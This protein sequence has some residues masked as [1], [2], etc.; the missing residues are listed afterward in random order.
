MGLKE[1]LSKIFKRQ[2][3]EENVEERI[4]RL[5]ID[6]VSDRKLSKR[7]E[8]INSLHD[9]IEAPIEADNVLKRLAIVRERLQA[10]NRGLKVVSVP[11]GRAGDNDMYREAMRGWERLYSIAMDVI[12]TVE[13]MIQSASNS[14][15]V[16]TAVL[17]P[18]VA[19][20]QINVLLQKGNVQAGQ[21][22]RKLTEISRTENF[23][24]TTF[25]INVE[26]LERKTESFL[27]I[28]VY[29]YAFLIMDVS[30]YNKDV[31]PAYTTVIQTIGQQPYINPRE[32]YPVPLGQRE[33][34]KHD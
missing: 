22:V 15:T 33:E 28:E 5:G 26:E 13:Q 18:E 19:E 34:K 9:A 32:P 10:V 8:L 17:D 12:S 16:E 14:E 3:E 29:P 23:L 24:V 25:K 7:I 21:I 30:Y 1:S 4:S 2:S 27:Q 11:Y 20:Q 31:A 6:V